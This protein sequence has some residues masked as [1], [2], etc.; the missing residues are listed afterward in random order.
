MEKKAN[1]TRMNLFKGISIK[2][3]NSLK[4]I[5]LESKNISIFAQFTRSSHLIF[6]NI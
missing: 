6:S 4:E 5:E 2:H 1:L 3:H